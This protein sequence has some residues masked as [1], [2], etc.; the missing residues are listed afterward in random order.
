MNFPFKTIGA[1][2]TP[3]P[4]KGRLSS[5]WVRDP[6]TGRLIQTWREADDSNGSCTRRPKGPR[7]F[8]ILAGGAPRAA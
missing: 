4:R 7:L 3:R 1:I 2:F 5:V 6:R 8:P